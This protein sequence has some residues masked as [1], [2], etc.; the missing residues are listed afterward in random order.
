MKKFL[1]VVAALALAVTIIPQANATSFKQAKKKQLV[2][3]YI[4]GGEA[5]PFVNQVTK[6]LRVEAKKRNIKMIECDTNF[7]TEKA[8][9]CAKTLYVARPAAMIN[10]QFDPSASKKVCANYKNLPTVTIDTPNDPCAKVFVGANNLQAG[11]TAGDYLGKWTKKN[12]ACDFDLFFA[13]ELPTLVDINKNRA[14]GTRT[15]FEKIC[16]AIPASKYKIIDKTSGGSD[17]V[18]NIRRQVTDLLTANPG[19]RAILGSSPFSDGDAIAFTKAFDT[20][21]RGTSL[22][23][24][25]PQGA[26]DVGH[27]YIRSDSRW[28]GSVGY[29]PERYGKLVIPA[30]IKLARGK[31]VPKEILTVHEVVDLSNIDKIYPVKK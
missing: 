31:K 8:L 19:A 13:V 28:I 24:I 4:S 30:V 2:I 21:G 7:L 3:G 17:P 10:W 1:S 23:A 18:E 12:L 16:G 5:S 14:G 9:E 26:E 22:K 27:E 20:A 15:G 29:F 11:L 6:S 25:L